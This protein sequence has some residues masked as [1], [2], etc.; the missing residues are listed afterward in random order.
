[1]KDKPRQAEL[2]NAD[3]ES[4]KRASA[5]TVVLERRE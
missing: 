1:V 5:V 3:R 2:V 4:T